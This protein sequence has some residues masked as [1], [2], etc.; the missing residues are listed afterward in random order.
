MTTVTWGD[1]Y[2]L[3][4]AVWLIQ[5]GMFVAKITGWMNRSWT[6]TFLPMIVFLSPAFMEYVFD[7]YLYVRQALK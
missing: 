4:I 3:V 1:I 5:A 2:V 7:L 6:F